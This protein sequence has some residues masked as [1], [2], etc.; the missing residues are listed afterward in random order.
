MKKKRYINTGL[1]GGGIQ[2][3]KKYINSTTYKRYIYTGLAGGS[4]TAL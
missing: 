2:H 4:Y 3:Y 1:A